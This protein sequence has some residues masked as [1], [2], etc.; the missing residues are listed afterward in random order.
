MSVSQS[1]TPCNARDPGLIPGS[2]RSPGRMK[3][4]PTAV[5][6]PGESRGQ[7]SLAGYS[8]W[9]L[10]E[11]DTTE[12][13]HGLLHCRKMPFSKDIVCPESSTDLGIRMRIETRAGEVPPSEPNSILSWVGCVFLV[14]AVLAVSS[15]RNSKMKPEHT[16]VPL[17]V[18]LVAES[19]ITWHLHEIRG[20]WGWW[21]LPAT[22]K[23]CTCVLFFILNVSGVAGLNT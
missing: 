21:L 22:Q 17:N 19:P 7:R 4:P 12:W 10:R 14:G 2:W 9:G 20:P 16:H 18:S 1:V 3:W 5:F 13:M 8:P 15:Q 11:L 6:L 23:D